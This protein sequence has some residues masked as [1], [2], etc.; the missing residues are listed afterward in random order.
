MGLLKT[1]LTQQA[2][3]LAAEGVRL[4]VIGRREGLPADVLEIMDRA[5]ENSSQTKGF[6]LCL[7]INYGSRQELVDAIRNIAGQ[8]ESGTLS[9]SQIDEAAIDRALYT[10]GMPDPDL[11]IRTSGEL[12]LSNF[13]LW[14]ISYS[15]LW[16][17]KKLWPEFRREDLI[18]A[19]IDFANRDRR[20]G[21]VDSSDPKP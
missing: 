5:V 12:R 19:I 17:T 18:E 16:V 10:Q 1:Y 7:A 9:P 20:F 14:Q 21:A 2:A 6:T 4:K 8:V 15:E 11:V 3:T 13:L